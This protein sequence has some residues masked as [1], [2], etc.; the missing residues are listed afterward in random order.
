MKT[1]SGKESDPDLRELQIK[2]VQY[3]RQGERLILRYQRGVFV[4]VTDDSPEIIQKSAEAEETFMTM[5]RRLKEAGRNV[6]HH[7]TSPNFAPRVFADEPDAFVSKDAFEA[8]MLRL[9][10]SGRIR[11]EVYGKPSRTFER[12]VAK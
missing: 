3:G 7:S 5:L 9:F 11:V 2:K 10:K 12:I 4:P 8:A 6:S 1:S